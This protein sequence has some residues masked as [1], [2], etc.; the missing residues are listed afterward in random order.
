MRVIRRI[1]AVIVGFVFF[2]AGIL[3]LMDPLGAGL[4]VLEY[5]KFFHVSFLNFSAN[6]MGSALALVETIL[7]AALITGVWRR[8]VAWCSFGF[9][10]FF[11]LITAILA[12]ANPVMDC[13]C[14]GE[15][16]HL[17]HVQTLLKNVALLALWALAF[18]PFS[19]LEPTR[20]VKYVSFTITAISSALFLLYSSLTIPLMDFTAYK[21]G[22]EL[23]TPETILSFSDVNGEYRDELVFDEKVMV[24]SVYNTEKVCDARWA[25]ISS[26][27]GEA[28]N[29]G[30]TPLLLVSSTPDMFAE[31]LSAPELLSCS[32]FADRKTLMT[33]NR[34]NG[35]AT[36]IA[37]GQVIGKWSVNKLPSSKELSELGATDTTE[38]LIE[39]N[40]AS[41]LK[42]QGFLLY[43]FA[44]MLLL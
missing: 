7:G 21:A 39:L 34:S 18:L 35:G 16:I 9:I 36:Y 19:S 42:M 32:Y 13:G 5:F 37:D 44:L 31:Q 15:A 2:I 11:T 17:T 29:C 40:N 6:F 26:L 27:L 22:A 14:F 8:I 4:V 38:A 1:S 33:L 25:K 23:M 41:G 43:V 12:I 28:E 10:S 20:K 24:V 3:K 30:F